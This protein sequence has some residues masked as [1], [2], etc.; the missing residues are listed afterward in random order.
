MIDSLGKFIMDFVIEHVTAPSL[1]TTSA[2]LVASSAS[3][4]KFESLGTTTLD[5]IGTTEFREMTTSDIHEFPTAEAVTETDSTQ[6]AFEDSAA[7]ERQSLYP[8][9]AFQYPVTTGT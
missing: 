3:N 1:E 4:N 8:E 2:I 9:V 7:T 6:I 5:S